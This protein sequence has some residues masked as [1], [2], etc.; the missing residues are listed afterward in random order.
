MHNQKG[1]MGCGSLVIICWLLLM[2]AVGGVIILKNN[3]FYVPP[4]KYV[5]S[6]SSAAKRCRQKLEMFKTNKYINNVLLSELE[7]NSVLDDEFAQANHRP[8]LSVTVKMDPGLLEIESRVVFADLFPPI[9]REKLLPE[10]KKER[11]E[12]PPQGVVINL[13][14][15]PVI[16]ENGN[17]FI[18]P[19]AL[20]IGKQRIP[21][22]IINMINAIKPDWFN[23]PVAEEISSIHIYEQE[24]EIVKGEAADDEA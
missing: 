13:S 23:Y 12:K 24:L 11:E 4:E 14:C 7:V 2:L 19:Q 21:L 9:I 18:N 16:K 17:L 1:V 3:L 15:Q 22:F 20:I 10:N 8:L 5:L 6:S